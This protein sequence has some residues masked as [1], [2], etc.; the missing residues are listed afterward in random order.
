M[1]GSVSQQRA[2]GHLGRCHGRRA[3]RRG[4]G[5]HVRRAA[6]DEAVDDNRLTASLIT[7]AEAQLAR[8]PT[9]EPDLSG[10]AGQ[11]PK[12]PVAGVLGFHVTDDGG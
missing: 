9:P 12:S 8:A 5:E 7:C 6:L 3:S 10:K 11:P 1:G 4:A 2:G